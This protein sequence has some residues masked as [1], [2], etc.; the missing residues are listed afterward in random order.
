MHRPTSRL[1]LALAVAPLAAGGTLLAAPAGAAPDGS[2]LVVSEVYGGGGNSGATLTN[3]FVE[4]FNPTAAPVDVD[5]LS[6][7][8]ASRTGS[9]WQVTELSGSM[10]AGGS[11]LVQQSRGS[12]GSE[13][14][15]APDVTGSVF[16]SATQGKVALVEGDEA[17]DGTCPLDGDA[18]DRVLDFVGYGPSAS[19]SE[20]SGPAPTLSNTT[21]AQRDADGT[22]SD[23]NAADFVEGEPMP[24][25]S[26]GEGRGDGTG[27]EAPERVLVS[28]VQGAALTSPLVGQRVEVQ[29]VVT[30]VGGSGF[31]VQEE[32]ADADGDEA[33]S[34]GL[35]VFDGFADVKPAVGD[36]VTVQGTVGEFFPGG[37]GTGN[38]STTQLTAPEYVVEASGVALPAVT[39]VGDEGRTP[40]TEVVDDDGAT[41]FDPTTDGLDFYESLEGMRLE[42]A[43]AVAVG[44]TTRFGEIPVADAD[45][46][47]PR[48]V[49]GGALLRED[50]PNPEV[51]I[52]DDALVEDEPSVTTGTTFAERPVGVLDYSFGAFKLLVTEPLVVG[53]PGALAADSADFPTRPAVGSYNVENLMGDA[54]QDEFDAIAEQVVA[55]LDS[56]LVLALQEVQDD[57]GATNSDVV[58][59]DVTLQRLA[60]AIAAA[61]GPSYAVTD[62]DPVDDADGGQPGG[63][64]RVAF[65]YDREAGV[66]LFREDVGGAT[67]AVEVVELGAR[68]FTTLSPNPGR[69]E[70][71]AAAFDDSRKPLAAHFR[72]RGKSVFVINV[73]FNSKGGDDSVFGA[74]QPP[75]RGS[76]VQRVAQATEVRELVDELLASDPQARVVVTG[77]FNDFPWSDAL[78]VVETGGEQ[79]DLVNLVETLPAA[80][81]YTFTFNGNSQVLDH[82]LV[83]PAVAELPYEFD[84]LHLNADRPSDA[85]PSDHDP[86]VLWLPGVRPRG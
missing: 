81:Q 24:T 59:A 45:V 12:G 47:E 34:E 5:G 67:E 6:V 63:N 31:W 70:P 18:A 51:L 79:A 72:Y 4:L 7:Q 11:Y 38:L 27:G 71:T 43:D 85:R 37:E 40:P 75:E 28:Q 36:L 73:H 80:D 15:P 65:L 86:Q 25:N 58:S 14:L 26:E 69:V 21:S 82:T 66:T 16:L 50:D 49:N 17:L 77:D 20:G 61:G 44:P 56:P 9:S 78:Q 33:T 53:T 2:G 55:E 42:V 60:D 64:I 30:A 22:D 62:V 19:C 46:V 39:V 1:A 57:D 76:E 83:S 13:E 23:D 48:T 68:E 84:V 8:Y 3:D 29:A 35:F 10:P 74:V 32:D 41:R 52:T 54:D